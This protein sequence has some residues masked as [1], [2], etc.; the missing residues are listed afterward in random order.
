[1]AG[2]DARSQSLDPSLSLHWSITCKDLAFRAHYFLLSSH[3]LSKTV[4]CLLRP[5]SR[6]CG[7][8]SGW[9]KLWRVWKNYSMN[10]GTKKRNVFSLPFFC[11]IHQNVHTNNHSKWGNLRT[12]CVHV[13]YSKKIVQTC[14]GTIWISGTCLITNRQTEQ[15]ELALK[16]ACPSKAWALHS[17]QKQLKL[18]ADS[19]Q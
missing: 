19:R 9:E 14:D 13:G 2:L 4:Q 3:T 7:L 18:L 5:E 12:N 11:F 8:G 15:S 6:G 10:F 1:M 16:A 17:Q